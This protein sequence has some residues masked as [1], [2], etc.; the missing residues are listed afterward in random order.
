M[1]L[2]YFLDWKEEI[3]S[4]AK[5]LTKEQMGRMFIS[6]QSFEGLQISVHSHIECTKFL[7]QNGVK[8]ILTERFMQDCLEEYFGHQGQSGRS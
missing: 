5:Q 4:K 7:L 3:D 2:K 8:Y 6:L 1:F